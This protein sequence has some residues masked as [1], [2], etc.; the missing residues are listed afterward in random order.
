MRPATRVVLLTPLG[1]SAVASLLVDGSSATNVVDAL[2]R[3][4]GKRTLAAQPY[5]RIV[6]G[7]W[8]SSTAGEE[9]VVCRRTENRIEIH[10]H[11]GRAAARAIIATLTAQGCQ[12]IVWTEWAR[13]TSDDPI[14]AD[15][16][17]ALAAALTERTALLLWQQH[18]GSLR[19]TIDEIT[20]RIAAGDPTS[21][22]NRI[23]RLLAW[24]KLGLHLTKP[25]RVVLTGRPNVGKS[26]L[27]NAL[28]GYHRA[29][30]H[31]TPGTTRDIVTAATAVDGWP[32][33]LADTAGIR[34][35][36]ETLERQGID[37]ARQNALDADLV[38]LI[39]DRSRPWSDEDAALAADWPQALSV[40]Y[41]C[42]LPPAAGFAGRSGIEVSATQ[43]TGIDELIAAI[44][45][46]LVPKVPAPDE[47]LPFLL[48]HVEALT[49]AGEAL[50]R[51][52]S[53][54][55]LGAFESFKRR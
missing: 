9:V 51:D 40:L 30:V 3:P 20:T 52:D 6:F 28:V 54:A 41:M 38:L 55:A 31:A 32:I 17:I 14:V 45:R 16:R 22:R 48:E 49:I 12:E 15:A 11:G 29:I 19:R 24:S 7:R 13:Q 33:E 27:I 36:G 34:T 35:G 43:G 39:F 4:A 8:P 50:A 53:P 44:A 21:A 2:F 47:A 37:R 25:W 5:G 18:E 1:R 23:E 10:C 46:R 26:S 42:D